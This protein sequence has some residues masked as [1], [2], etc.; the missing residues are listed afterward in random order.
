MAAA[1]RDRASVA[2]SEVQGGLASLRNTAERA[3]IPL[4]NGAL[5]RFGVALALFPLD[6]VKTRAQLRTAKTFPKPQQLLKGAGYLVNPKIALLRG[7]PAGALAAAGAGALSFIVYSNMIARAKSATTVASPSI[8]ALPRSKIGSGILSSWVAA[9]VAAST[10]A[11]PLEG[12][13]TRVQLGIY[14]TV[15]GALKGAFKSGIFG[16]YSGGFAHLA[17]ELP[18]RA[19]FIVLAAKIGDAIAKR[20]DGKRLSGPMEASVTGA[21]VAAITAPLDLVR[22]RVLAQRVGASKLHANFTTCAFNT[23]KNEGP[24]AAFRG[25]PFRVAHLALSVGLFAAAYGVTERTLSEKKW[26][27]YA[28]KSDSE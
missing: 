15:P 23:V 12:V 5:A 27:W 6:T 21:A 14:N 18:T 17:R 10:W 11:V 22:T 2:L 4:L 19:L 1:I 3:R 20:R 9:E 24:L 26:L 8:T 25:A 28:D 7:A 16:I 13:K